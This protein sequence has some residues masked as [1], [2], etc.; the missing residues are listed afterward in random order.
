MARTQEGERAARPAARSAS[1][2]VAFALGVPLAVVLLALLKQGVLGEPGRHYVKHPAEKVEVLLFCCAVT[3]LAFKLWQS[4]G[5][6]AACAAGVLPPWDG[7]PV[8][9]TEAAALR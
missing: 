2:L 1:T 7:R 8:P 6:R 5:E 4:R 3:A 9:T